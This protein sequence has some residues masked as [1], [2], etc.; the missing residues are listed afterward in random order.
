M[1]L[2]FTAQ[3]LFGCGTHA[4]GPKLDTHVTQTR[5]LWIFTDIKKSHYL[6]HMKRRAKWEFVL[7][8]LFIEHRHE[9]LKHSC[10]LLHFLVIW[11]RSFSSKVCWALYLGLKAFTIKSSISVY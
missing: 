1:Y 7:R 5:F 6:C 9:S 3:M 4:L 8:E 11:C 2:S 10:E